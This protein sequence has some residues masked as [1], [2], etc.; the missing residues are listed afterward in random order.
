MEEFISEHGGVLMSAI[1]SVVLLAIIF[2]VVAVVGKMEAYT[3]AS[4]S[5]ME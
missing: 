5:G 3:I 1:I 4:I 2:I